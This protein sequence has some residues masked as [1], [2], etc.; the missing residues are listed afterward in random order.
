MHI[1]E[2]LILL[3]FKIF[4]SITVALRRQCVTQMFHWKSSV[5][6]NLPGTPGSLARSVFFFVNPKVSYH[7][8]C[9]LTYFFDFLVLL[10]F[11]QLSSDINGIK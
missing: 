7:M 11:L 2:N 10:I 3:G 9:S 1:E 8:W 5:R 6:T 4:W